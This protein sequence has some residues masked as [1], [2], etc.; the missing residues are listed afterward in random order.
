MDTIIDTLEREHEWLCALFDEIGVALR[1][2]QTVREIRIL[3]CV[4]EGV[5]SRHADTERDLAYAALDHA[6]EEKGAL[7]RLYQD[8]QEIDSR[9]HAANEATN[10]REARQLLTVGLEA[11]RQ[12]FRREERTVFH[13]LRRVL[14]TASLAALA[15]GVFGP[16]AGMAPLVGRNAIP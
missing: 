13:L 12:H 7:D 16:Q 5:L 11:C 14:T 1:N 2:A 3:G 4:V 9:L 8:H 15:G 6:L 10:L